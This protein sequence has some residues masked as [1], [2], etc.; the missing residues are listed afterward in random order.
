MAARKKDTTPPLPASPA[1]VS[2]QAPETV[3]KRALAAKK[4]DRP[5]LKAEIIGAE[6]I[7]HLYGG[8]IVRCDVFN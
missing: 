5:V 3:I 4:I 7:L 8:E 2:E 6:L 1:S